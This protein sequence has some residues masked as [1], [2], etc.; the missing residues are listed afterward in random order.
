[1]T[2][3]V[4]VDTNFLVYLFDQREPAAPR[5]DTAETGTGDRRN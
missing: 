4:F 5:L 1:M 3:R 2:A